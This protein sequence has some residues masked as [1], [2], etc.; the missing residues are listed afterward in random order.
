MNNKKYTKE[1]IEKMFEESIYESELGK[2]A[3]EN[4]DNYSY[5]DC[6]CFDA[7]MAVRDAFIY[8]AE[9]VLNHLL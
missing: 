8:G 3:D 1:E 9:W 6:G 5:D 2:A 4:A 7:E